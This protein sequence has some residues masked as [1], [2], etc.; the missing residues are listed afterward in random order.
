MNLDDKKKQYVIR[1]PMV[2]AIVYDD[3]DEM[4]MALNGKARFYMECDEGG[5][6]H[7]RGFEELAGENYT[8]QIV[9][10]GDYIVVDGYNYYLVTKEEFEEKYKE[11]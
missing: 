11:I 9:F 5:F 8:S 10:K 6:A 4:D 3:T 7:L 2:T 1:K